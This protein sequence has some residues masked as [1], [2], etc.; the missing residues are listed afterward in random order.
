MPLEEHSGG[1]FVSKAE[2]CLGQGW[3]RAHFPEWLLPETVILKKM[4]PDW[5]E[6]FANEKRMV[7]T[8]FPLSDSTFLSQIRTTGSRKESRKRTS[9]SS[10][11]GR[12]CSRRTWSCTLSTRLVDARMA[13]V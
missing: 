8:A 11:V 1:A 6:E 3:L 13:R 7:S 5:D 4:K 10:L 9:W 2:T 12:I